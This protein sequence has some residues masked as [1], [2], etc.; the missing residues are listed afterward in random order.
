[1]DNHQNDDLGDVMDNMDM[2][3]L[4]LREAVTWV[5][6][7]QPDAQLYCLRALLRFHNCL[8]ALSSSLSRAIDLQ[9]RQIGTQKAEGP[10]GFPTEPSH[11]PT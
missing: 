10:M 2:A 4:F 8:G 1:M 7:R 9:S 3:Q 6:S 11:H 5:T